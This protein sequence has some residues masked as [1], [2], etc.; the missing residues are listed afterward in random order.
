M[1]EIM[2]IA[3]GTWRR[4]LRM[5]VVYFLIVCVL[6]LIGSAVNYDVLSMGEHRALMIDVSL[7]LNTVAA[8][9]ISIS[10]C[11][12]IP[13]ELREGVASTL[14]TKPLGR[15]QYLVGKLFGTCVTGF[16][17]TGL[18]A[19]GFFFIYSFAFND[20][21]VNSMFQGHLL[22]VASV[23]PMSGLALLFSVFI[24][25]MLTALVTAAVIW[26][27]FSSPEI[28]GVSLIYGGI[29]P[30]LN[31]FNLKALAVYGDAINWP[32]IL[33]T[34]LWGCVYAVFTSTL[35]SLIFQYKDIK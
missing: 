10:I 18:I 12:E 14:L 2:A 32:Y 26:F 1:N 28:S 6:I 19:I 27:S 17:I 22:V 9:L 21:V 23:V 7:V 24:P 15:T 8:V 33:K 13:R 29:I 34:A 20:K 4:I 5:R 30:D 35:A 16:I 3:E 31:L 11:F 25:E